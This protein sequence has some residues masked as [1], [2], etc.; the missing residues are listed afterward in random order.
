L[1]NEKSVLFITKNEA[2]NEALKRF[3][4]IEKKMDISHLKEKHIVFLAASRIY[5]STK[6]QEL[7]DTCILYGCPRY[8]Q[9]DIFSYARARRV[10]IIAYE[11]EI[12]SIK[13]IQNEIDQVQNYFSD[14][15]KLSIVKRL[16]GRELKDLSSAAT[17]KQEKIKTELI[18]IDPQDVEMGD[19]SPES[20]LTNFLSLDWAIDFEYINEAETRSVNERLRKDHSIPTKAVMITLHGGRHILLHEEKPVQVYDE[21]TEKVKDR[22]GKNL[23]KGDLL[24]LIENSTRKSLAQSV[25]SKVESHPSMM[26]VIVYQKAWSYY[27]KQALEESGDSFID[28]VEKLHKGGAKEPNTAMSIYQWINGA[29]IGPGDL[30]NVRR[31]G[32]IYDKPF[33]VNNYKEI[34]GAI[35]RLRTIHRSLARRLN[36]LIP[37]AGIEADKGKIDNAVIDEE[38]DLYLEDFVNIVSIERIGSVEIIGISSDKVLDNVIST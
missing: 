32:E 34:A 7:F 25:I 16:T 20:I 3:L 36:R 29:I 10:G 18:F 9:K 24:I 4:E 26:K 8:Y 19:I 17:P 22:L 2:L 30:E 23:K 28:L 1:T 21:S 31:I 27:L 13:Y 37:L 11:S 35:Q 33:L 38:L 15:S 5:K 6:E 14:A 12:P